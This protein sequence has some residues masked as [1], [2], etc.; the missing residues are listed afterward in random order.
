[1][2]KPSEKFFQQEKINEKNYN[3]IVETRTGK[4]EGDI[5]GSKL[6]KFF[7]FMSRNLEKYC[8]INKKDF[9][10]DNKKTGKNYFNI[11]IKKEIILQGPP[12]NKPENLLRFREKHK[13]VFIKGDKSFAREKV[14]LSL[15]KFVEDIKK[16]GISKEMGITDLKILKNN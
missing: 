11:K 9:E 6:I 5:A 10:Y 8:I 3:F 16:S 14:N 15:G 4:Q 13:N 12:I 7:G 1:M 2:K